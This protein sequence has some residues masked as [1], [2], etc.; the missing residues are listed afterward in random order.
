[1]MIY[2]ALSYIVF[3]L[4]ALSVSIKARKRGGEAA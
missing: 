4:F 2:L 1:M 3:G